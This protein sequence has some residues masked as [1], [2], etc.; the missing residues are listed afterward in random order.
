MRLRG[1]GRRLC[2]QLARMLGMKG[3]SADMFSAA[4]VIED[5]DPFMYADQLEH[6]RL[7]P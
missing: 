4:P 3:V 6:W 7:G 1:E 2:L 5:D